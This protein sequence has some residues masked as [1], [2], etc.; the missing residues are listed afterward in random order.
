[1]KKAAALG[2][3]LVAAALL[4][5]IS[6]LAASE[7]G[8]EI[9][10]LTTVGY[11]DISPATSIGQA[12]AAVIMIMGYGMIAVPTGIVTVELSQHTLKGVSTQA[13]MACSAEGPDRAAVHCKYC[14]AR[15]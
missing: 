5:V 4:F 8:E 12:F 15:R 2:G 1:M 6:V 3:I 10:T 14:G 7:G 13:C 11:G 9:V